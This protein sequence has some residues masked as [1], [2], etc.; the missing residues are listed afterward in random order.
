[1]TLTT[2]D[3]KK[4][5][6]VEFISLL[7]ETNRCP[8]GKDTIRRILQNAFVTHRSRVLE[9]GSNTGFTSLEIART[10]KCRTTGIDVIPAAVALS[11]EL[12][13]KDTAEI[14]KLVRFGSGS[15][16]EIPFRPG[17]FDLVVTGG[18]TSFMDDKSRAVREYHRVLKPWGFLS[19]TTLAYYRKPPARVIKAVSDTIG[20]QIEPWGFEEWHDVFSKNGLFESY[21]EERHKMIAV[22]AAKLAGFVDYFMAKPHIDALPAPVRREVRRRWTDTLRVFNENHRYLGYL[23]VLFRKRHLPEEMELFTAH[24]Q[25]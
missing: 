22:P 25:L 11:R 5:N 21:Y 24:D 18:A 4:M 13:V 1:M 8:G 2:E 14:R 20:V 6:Y 16:Y 15:A 9:V 23:L 19:V 7:E 17:S 3:V 10:A 12:L